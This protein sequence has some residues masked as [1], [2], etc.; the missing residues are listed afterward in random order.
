MA[1]VTIDG[2]VSKT[3]DEIVAEL[4][5]RFTSQ[6]GATFDVSPESPDGQTIGIMAD[7]MATQWDMGE[8]TFNSYNPATSAG[9][10]LDNAVRINAI[11]RITN[12]PTTAS[13]SLSASNPIYDGTLIPAGSVVETADGIQFTT[14]D[15]VNLPGTTIATCTTLGAI[16][17]NTAE[18]NTIVTVITG[19]DEVTNAVAG[20]TGIVEETDL[21]LRARREATVVRT[22]ITTADAVV[23]AVTNVA[24][25]TNVLVIE[26]DNNVAVGVIPAN[27]FHTIVDG[28]ILQSI[29]E[30]VYVN[31]PIGILAYGSNV[32]VVVDSQLQNHN[33]G[34]S[35]PTDVVIKIE[36]SI[37]KDNTAPS[38]ANADVQ[39]ALV[40]YIDTFNMGDDVVWSRLFEPANSITGTTVTNIRSAKIADGF[41][42]ITIPIENVEKASLILANVTI[43]EV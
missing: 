8:D 33:I 15:P 34:V 11:A 4:N 39:Q 6:F 36:V 3:R 41:T 42:E 28:G 43:I 24:G 27:S 5:A 2:F 21:A 19:W 17:I 1:G 23:S 26:N 14:D 16:I 31:K 40:D 25:V 12:Q 37:T 10:P 38:T 7:F 20:T 32:Q 35:R 22:G 13:V 9:I 18:I 30:A 29:A